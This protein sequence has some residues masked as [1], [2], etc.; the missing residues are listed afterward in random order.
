M[1]QQC[2]TR[3]AWR[4]SQIDARLASLALTRDDI[5]KYSTAKKR[6]QRRAMSKQSYEKKFAFLMDIHAALA[7]KLETIRPV[8]PSDALLDADIARNANLSE[9]D[10]AA[11]VERAIEATADPVP[12]ETIP[13]KSV[14]PILDDETRRAIA[15]AEIASGGEA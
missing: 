1:T 12:D 11:R 8:D 4:K 7:P 14:D 3:K 6:K 15:K 5:R 10:I 13:A 9:N 2:L